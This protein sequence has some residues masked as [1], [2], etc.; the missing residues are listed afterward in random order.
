[1][2]EHEKYNVAMSLFCREV[3]GRVAPEIVTRHVSLRFDQHLHSAVVPEPRG[4]HERGG[5]PIVVRVDVRS[6]TNQP[7]GS[8]TAAIPARLY[9]FPL[10]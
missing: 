1:M 5:L 4:V 10:R 2:S 9:E 3:H 7:F 8:A 6:G